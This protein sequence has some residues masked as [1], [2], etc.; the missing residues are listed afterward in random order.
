MNDVKQRAADVGER[1]D[2]QRWIRRFRKVAQDM[3]A[4]VWVFVASG[5]PCVMATDENGEHIQGPRGRG[6]D[7]D[8]IITSV[9]GG[10]WDGG[11]F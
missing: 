5:T 9:R 2:V 3:P 7:Q 8:A 10:S 6:N 11:D 1:P 4:D